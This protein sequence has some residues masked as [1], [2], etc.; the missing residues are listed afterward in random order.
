MSSSLSRAQS[1]P[2]LSGAAPVEDARQAA[3]RTSQV[4]L[5]AGIAAIES[6]IRMEFYL[7]ERS[8]IFDVCVS[9]N[10]SY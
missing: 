7:L 2:L 3:T 4:G 5:W 6:N 9:L 8:A 1:W 10:S